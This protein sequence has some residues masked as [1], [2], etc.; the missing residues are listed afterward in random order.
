[1]KRLPIFA[2]IAALPAAALSLKDWEARTNAAQVEYL[3]GCLAR[4][5]VAIDKSDKPLAERIRRYYGDKPAGQKSSTGM[6]DLLQRIGRV[7]RDRSLDLSK[8]EIEDQILKTTVAKFGPM[9]ATVTRAGIS[10]PTRDFVEVTPKP[11]IP[12][13][14]HETEPTDNPIGPGGFITAPQVRSVADHRPDWIGKTMD[15]QGTVSRVTVP[16]VAARIVFRE[17]PDGSFQVF[18]PLVDEL[19]ARF[20]RDLAGLIGKTIRVHGEVQNFDGTQGGI[21]FTDMQQFTV[22]EPPAR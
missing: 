8:V 18:T 22:I 3:T 9:P 7:E 12:P 11:G 6:L 19:R 21:R 16:G 1:M 5:V 15:V 10:A 14:V 20:G 2:L 17:A 4:L 13:T